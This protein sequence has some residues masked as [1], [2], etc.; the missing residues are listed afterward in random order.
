MWA[1]W[2]SVSLALC[3]K[4]VTDASNNAANTLAS[5]TNS[6]MNLPAT[7]AAAALLYSHW[8]L[9]AA[10]GSR[11]SSAW[12]KGVS[13]LGQKQTFGKVTPMSALHHSE[14]SKIRSPRLRAKP[15]R[16]FCASF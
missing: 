9:T 11:D 8:M 14:A 5:L 3:A 16:A 4:T 7:A 12:T 2:G 15:P 6:M 1:I 13:A 10:Q